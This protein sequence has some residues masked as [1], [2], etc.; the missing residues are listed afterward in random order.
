MKR[1]R[2]SAY[3]SFYCAFCKILSYLLI[4]LRLQIFSKKLKKKKPGAVL[5]LRFLFIEISLLILLSNVLSCYSQLLVESC[6]G[7]YCLSVV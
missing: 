1:Y 3:V 2:S 5:L 7:V 6:K 4:F